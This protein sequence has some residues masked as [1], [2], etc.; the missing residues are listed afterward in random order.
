MVLNVATA[1]KLGIDLPL[2]MLK[3]ADRVVV[4]E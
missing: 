3:R 2:D 4:D 1:R